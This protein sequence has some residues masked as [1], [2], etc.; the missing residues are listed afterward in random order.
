MEETISDFPAF[1]DKLVRIKYGTIGKVG[2]VPNKVIIS[3]KL[4]EKLNI[5]DLIETIGLKIEHDENL[6]LEEMKI[7]VI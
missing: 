6:G 4:A 5:E 3:K 2:R 1:L 7:G